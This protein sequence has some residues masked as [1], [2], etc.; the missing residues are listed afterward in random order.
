MLHL[1]KKNNR[2]SGRL[3]LQTAIG[4]SVVSNINYHVITISLHVPVHLA[5][6]P[7]QQLK[8]HDW[9]ISMHSTSRRRVRLLIVARLRHLKKNSKQREDKNNQTGCS[10]CSAAFSGVSVRTELSRLFESR[11]ALGA[12]KCH[13]FRWVCRQTRPIYMNRSLFYTF[14]PLQRLR[15]TSKCPTTDTSLKLLS[16]YREGGEAA[17]CALSVLS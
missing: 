11:P 17:K 6:W 1:V 12:W 3:P 13:S 2:N 7:C 10:V 15:K 5:V 4:P 8:S 9:L 16:R 14:S